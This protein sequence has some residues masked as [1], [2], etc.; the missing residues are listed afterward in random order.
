MLALLALQIEIE[1]IDVSALGRMPAERLTHYNRVLQDQAYTLDAQIAERVAVY[2]IE[3]DLMMKDVTP[4]VVEQAL[5]ARVI[6]AR[7]TLDSI[8]RD[9]VRLA[10]PEQRRAALNDLPD[11]ADDGDELEDLSMFAEMFD[12]LASPRQRASRKRKRRR[13]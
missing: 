2:R 13:R 6:Q 8:E 12:E 1:Q 4:R 3:F 10:D 5:S 11:P 7:A 9:T